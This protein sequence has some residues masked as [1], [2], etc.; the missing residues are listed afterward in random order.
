ML[1]TAPAFLFLFLPLAL[2][3]SALCGKERRRACLLVVCGVYQVIAHLFHPQTLAVLALLILYTFLGG[4]LIRRAKKN[5][6]AAVICLLPYVALLILRFFAYGGPLAEAYP[7]GLTMTIVAST[8]Y[9][10]DRRRENATRARVTDLVLYLT[11]FPILLVGPFVR[12]AEFIELTREERMSLNMSRFADGAR[13]YMVGFVKRI[14]V[15]AVIMETYRFLLASLSLH[16]DGAV[17]LLAMLLIYFAAFFIITGYADMACG[18]A[19]MLGV[20]VSYS[21]TRPLLVALPEDYGKTLLRGLYVWLEDDLLRPARALTGERGAH[22]ITAMAYGGLPLL[23]IRSDL[24]AFAMAIP[25]TLLCYVSVHFDWRSAL[26]HKKWLRILCMCLTGIGISF[27]WMCLTV[28]DAVTVAKHLFSGA[29]F[30][31]VYYLNLILVTFSAREYLF[32]AAVALFLLGMPM[33]YSRL[34]ATKRSG[35]R[36]AAEGVGSLL[37]LLVFAFAVLFFLPQFG[38][39]DTAPFRYV[40]I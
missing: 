10:L 40:F 32:L 1:L 18:V 20:P 22:L 36:S 39:Y 9:L 16:S 14:A 2:L 21:P 17:T 23:L 7:V 8:S 12:Y 3:L 31:S 15:G 24:T 19:W 13:L 11:F 35:A 29:Y 28:G 4:I 5:A 25:V 27:V 33:L 6:F 37:L 30:N 38:S 34:S 26:E